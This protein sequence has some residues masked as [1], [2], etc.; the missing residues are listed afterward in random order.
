MPA[1]DDAAMPMHALPPEYLQV[2]RRLFKLRRASAEAKRFTWESLMRWRGQVA[3][4]TGTE[5][6]AP[7]VFTNEDGAV[8]LEWHTPDR[9]HCLTLHPAGYGL[10]SLTAGEARR[11]IRPERGPQAKWCGSAGRRMAN[12]RSRRVDAD[13]APNLGTC[14]LSGEVSTRLRL[15]SEWPRTRWRVP[16]L[17]RSGSTRG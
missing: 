17:P 14:D 16:Q 11:T 15:R 8:E 12:G 2:E 6:P 9:K 5:L 13:R 3:Q 10:C 4:L 7:W 1:A